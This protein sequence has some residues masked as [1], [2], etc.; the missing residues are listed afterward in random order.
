[1]PPT[2]TVTFITN[3]GNSE[4]QPVSAVRGDTVA[5][6]TVTRGYYAF[7]GWYSDIELTDKVTFPYAVTKSITLYARWEQTEFAWNVTF[8]GQ[9]A[10]IN[11]QNLH[12]NDIYL[13]KTN[14]SDSV[15][16]A[17]NTGR[18]QGDLQSL[19]YNRMTEHLQTPETAL[20]PLLDEIQNFNATPPP[21]DKNASYR[22]RAVPFIPPVVGDKRMFWV[23]NTGFL[24]TG[25]YVEIPAT[26][27]ASGLHGNI[28]VADEVYNPAD[29][30]DKL[31]TE[32]AEILSVKFD[33]IYPLVTNIMG[34]EYGG[35]PD[36][37]GGIDGDSK[38]QILFYT[39]HSM[40]RYSDFHPYFLSLDSNKCEMMYLHYATAKWPNYVGS[41][42]YAYTY[43]QMAHE[44]QHLINFNQK[45][46]K[47]GLLLDKWDE[48]MFSLMIE[49][50]IAPFVCDDKTLFITHEVDNIL[51]EDEI[52]RGVI[53][54]SI[55]A[56]GYSMWAAFGA[57]LL[58]NFGG[59]EL[60]KNI[61]AN[62]KV[63]IESITEALNKLYP[64]MNF[65]K[66]LT[67][68]AEAFIYSGSNIPK[69]AMTF[70]KTST[71]AINGIDYTIYGFDI[72]TFDV[73]CRRAPDYIPY[74]THKGPHVFD[75][76]P[77]DMRPYSVSL[78]TTD[79]W[80]NRSGN[81]S[82]TLEKPADPN[83]VLQLM[84]K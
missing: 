12:N 47:H 33:L 53:E 64:G 72:Y 78:H 75:L 50:L 15:V 16:P 18:V 58:S 29:D 70:D 49:Q 25:A 76:T 8:T 59:A 39:G 63:G 11:F 40:I 7:E 23:N 60:F 2:F 81:V 68:F 73:Y 38:I 19:V 51:H 45:Y 61:I 5:A 31:T 1:M 83:I 9:T 66:A 10:T 24:H 79:A 20:S 41:E 55:T 84:I 77:M 67:R 13:V 43:I 30:G 36:G 21:L 3:G 46:V 52:K 42:K 48:E 32:D 14:L 62:D 82:V 37:D 4:L 17:A 34:F 69:N 57:Y 26:L 27:R 71:S 22:L 44:L 65:E 74:D 54:G 56:D 35:G 80:K 6:P 28:W